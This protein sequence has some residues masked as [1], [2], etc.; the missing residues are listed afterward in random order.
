MLK[1]A[2][3]KRAIQKTASPTV[4]W[5]KLELNIIFRKM[6]LFNAQQQTPT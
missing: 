2:A 4:P 5:N 1:S 3:I 6:G